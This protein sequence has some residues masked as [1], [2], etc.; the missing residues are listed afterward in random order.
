MP[1]ARGH[2]EKGTIDQEPWS[3]GPEV[4]LDCNLFILTLELLN[5]KNN[6]LNI[7]SILQLTIFYICC[8][9]NVSITSHIPIPIFL[10]CYHIFVQ[11]EELCRFALNR[12]YRLLPH[13]YTLFY[14]A[15]KIGIPVMTPL[16]FA[17]KYFKFSFCILIKSAINKFYC[18]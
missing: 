14:Q 10:Q 15:N 11:V 16:F 17:G 2:S 18:T 1:F 8:T 4:L 3:F 9:Q 12:R 6:S 7:A 13:F 5:Q